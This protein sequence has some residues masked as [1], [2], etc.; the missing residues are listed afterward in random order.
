MPIN[1]ENCK[2]NK[3]VLSNVNEMKIYILCEARE[4]NHQKERH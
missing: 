4:L 2:E 3:N 1:C